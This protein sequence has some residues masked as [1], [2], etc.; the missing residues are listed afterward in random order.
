MPQYLK[1]SSCLGIKGDVNA[2][3][4]V[5][6][7]LEAI[8]VINTGHVTAAA[9]VVRPAL[10]AGNKGGKVVRKEARVQ[11]KGNKPVG[12][13]KDKAKEKEGKQPKEDDE[14]E[15]EREADKKDKPLERK[16]QRP[17]AVDEF[18][19][20]RFEHAL[21]KGWDD[22]VDSSLDKERRKKKVK[23]A[24]RTE[25]C[26]ASNHSQLVE[27]KETYMGGMG[28]FVCMLSPAEMNDSI[29]PARQAQFSRRQA[30]CPRGR[31]RKSEW[32]SRALA[33]KPNMITCALR[34]LSAVG[35][36]G[37]PSDGDRL[38]VEVVPGRRVGGAVDRRVEEGP[39]PQL[40]IVRLPERLDARDVE[41]R[42]ERADVRHR[43]RRAV[44]DARRARAHALELFFLRL[45]A[46]ARARGGGGDDRGVRER[47]RAQRPD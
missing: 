9:A 17:P 20:E 45:D 41:D 32:L 6:A 22:A 33:S 47:A 5:H 24:L 29:A 36:V 1:K 2:I 19:S 26:L 31:L 7:Y 35:G 34:A 28:V 39:R 4:R 21:P 38:L 12:K 18:Y 10:V 8:G 43:R 42:L 46:I 25:A 14:T 11:A 44:E 23:G 37:G 16:N 27:S 3:G 30:Q 13:D 15:D 40:Q